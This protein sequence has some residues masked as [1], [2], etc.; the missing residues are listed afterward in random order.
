M[1]ETI[2]TARMQPKNTCNDIAE[3]IRRKPEFSGIGIMA[4]DVE[5]E[6]R[7]MKAAELGQR[8]PF[9]LFLHELCSDPA[10]YHVVHRDLDGIIDRI[11][12]TYR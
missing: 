10:I 11:F 9:Q 4:R 1:L 3:Q 12:W 6:V 2:Q 5:S 8:T 7:K